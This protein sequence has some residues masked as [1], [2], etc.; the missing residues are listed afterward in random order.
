MKKDKKIDMKL[1]KKVGG[2]LPL[3]LRDGT[4]RLV[5]PIDADNLGSSTVLSSKGSSAPL[6]KGLNF[7]SFKM[8]NNYGEKL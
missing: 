6:K 8:F 2:S 3:H 4:K 7:T 1:T 5:T